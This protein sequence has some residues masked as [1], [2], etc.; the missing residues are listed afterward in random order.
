MADPQTLAVGMRCD[1]VLRHN[2]T[3]IEFREI[4]GEAVAL[5]RDERGFR[6]PIAISELVPLPAGTPSE[7][8]N[9]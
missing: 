6:W 1:Q 5:C 7:D 2:V 9:G 4:A 3:I 8:T